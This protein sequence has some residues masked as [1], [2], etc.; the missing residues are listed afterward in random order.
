MVCSDA[1]TRGY[2]LNNTA[3]LKIFASTAGY[4]SIT[5]ST[6]ERPIHDLAVTSRFT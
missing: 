2:V 4:S 1:S 3:S 6:G 5:G